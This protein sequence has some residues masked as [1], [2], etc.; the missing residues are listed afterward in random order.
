[1]KKDTVVELRQ[2]EQGRV[3]SCSFSTRS[4]C[5]K[6]ETRSGFACKAELP[7]DQLPYTRLDNT[8]LTRPMGMPPVLKTFGKYVL[9]PLL[10][11][12]PPVDSST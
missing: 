6:D 8:S 7:S 5:A 12:S 4:K 1:M 9:A 11:R 2:P 10:Y 3:A